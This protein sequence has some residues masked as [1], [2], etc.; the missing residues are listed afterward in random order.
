MILSQ[1]AASIF[2]NEFIFM[3]KDEITFRKATI[4]EWKCYKIWEGQ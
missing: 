3:K 2:L 1:I 4:Q